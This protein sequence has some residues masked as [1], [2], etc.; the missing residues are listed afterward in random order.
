LCLDKHRCPCRH[1]ASAFSSTP[2]PGACVSTST[3]APVDILRAR[4][5]CP[6]LTAR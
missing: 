4:L 5:V 1:T 2:L 3:G 6:P